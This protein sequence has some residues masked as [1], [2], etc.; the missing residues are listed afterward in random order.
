M[1]DEADFMA[2]FSTSLAA[3]VGASKAVI[4]A[5][6]TGHG[7]HITGTL[8]QP[9]LVVTSEQSLPRKEEFE[10][11]AAGGAMLRARSAGRDPA[12][13]IAVLRLAEPLGPPSI[14]ASEAPTGALVIAIGSDGAG[15]ATARLGVVNLNGAEWHSQY[16]GRIDRRIVLDLRLAPH[17]EGGPVVDHAGRYVGMS[18]FGVR[19][20]VLAIPTATIERVVPLLV[21]DGRIARRWIGLSL[22]R[23]AIPEVLRQPA[24]QTSGLMVMSVMD[25]GP[26][27]K[28]GIVPGDIIVTVDGT[29]TDRFRTI[30]KHFGPDNIGRNVEIRLIRGGSVVAVKARIGERPP[31]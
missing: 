29:S 12:T 27:A 25:D 18:T 4:I 7:G 21:R 3:R 30:A 24:N 9:D 31:T 22:Q 20:Q 28:A 23:V 14:V 13:N 1:N 2:Q 17:E 19:G 10:A 8:W 6:R 26:A 11:V 15:D 5:I 16:G